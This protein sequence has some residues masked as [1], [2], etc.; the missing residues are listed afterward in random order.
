[1]QNILKNWYFDITSDTTAGFE[2][3]GELLRAF[4]NF[5]HSP[6][7]SMGFNSSNHITIV[8]DVIGGNRIAVGG[9]TLISK[10]PANNADP[11]SNPN[12]ATL[13]AAPAVSATPII[14][15][16]PTNTIIDATPYAYQIVTTNNT[17]YHLI[18]SDMDPN[19]RKEFISNEK[20]V[21]IDF[22]A[23]F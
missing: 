15:K 7:T 22:A 8:G 2:A 11:T 17:I 3:F 21:H 12:T 9:I 16:T 20:I 19:F 14:S 5:I 18:E 1:M 10:I 13:R 6:A 4:T 23:S